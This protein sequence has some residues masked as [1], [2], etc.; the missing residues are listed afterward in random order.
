M[1]KQ[2]KKAA[3]IT[4]TAYLDDVL[5]YSYVFVTVTFHTTVNV[6]IDRYHNLYDIEFIMRMDG[7]LTEQLLQKTLFTIFRQC[8][9]FAVQ[10]L[11]NRRKTIVDLGMLSKRYRRTAIITADYTFIIKHIA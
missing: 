11:G 8:R 10:T 5:K 3:Q 2:Y 1:G 4:F 7:F 9:I 6:Y